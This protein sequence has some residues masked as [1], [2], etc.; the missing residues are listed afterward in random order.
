[1]RTTQLQEASTR[2]VQ[3]LFR[4]VPFAQ[5]QYIDVVFTTADTDVRL[6]HD[7]KVVPFTSLSYLVVRANKATTIYD[8]DVTTWDPSHFSVKSSE[9]DAEVTLLIFSRR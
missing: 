9:A 2:D 8:G 7:L 3:L 5:Y 4:G 1:M 6:R